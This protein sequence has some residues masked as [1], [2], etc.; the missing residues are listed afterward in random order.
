MKLDRNN[1]NSF[2]RL[3]YF[4]DYSNPRCRPG[5]RGID[6][7][8]YADRARGELAALGIAALKRAIQK[9]FRPGRKN[10]VPLSGGLDSRAILSGLLELTPAENITA[11]TYGAEWTQDFRI[12]RLVARAAGVK[13]VAYPLSPYTTGMDELLDISE[14]IDRQTVLFH[15]PPL[16]RL[17]ELAGDAVIWSGF[18]GD[19]VT[20]SHLPKKAL[21]SLP[22]E[23]ARFIRDN[24]F[25]RTKITD[26]AYKDEDLFCLIEAPGPG[27]GLTAAEQLD[28]MNRMPKYIAPHVLM[29]GFEYATPFMEKEFF[30][31]YYS[32]PDTL[33]VRQ[34]LYKN[35]LLGAFPELFRLPCKN[36]FGAPLNSFIKKYY[37]MAKIGFSRT[38]NHFYPL[39]PDTRLN[40]TDFGTEMRENMPFADII[41]M[42][43]ADLEKRRI[44]DWLDP[45]VLWR[46]HLNKKADNASAL[47]VLASLEIHMKSEETGKR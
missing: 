47:L 42:N 32:L 4:L 15:N 36:D 28:V 25:V 34:N 24:T 9:S 31:F 16:N 46:D 5:L 2:L 35:C 39:I 20:G 6:K 12:G 37:E 3:G 22:E 14:R 27:T 17:T 33:R 40:Y 43:I 10:V 8:R 18:W 11:Y 30:D 13:H 44:L 1:L 19:P 23:K 38:V 26:P 7:A 41:R 45:D 29:R 21:R